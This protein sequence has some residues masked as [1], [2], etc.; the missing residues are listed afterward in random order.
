VAFSPTDETLAVGYDNEEGGDAETRKAWPASRDAPLVL[1]GHQG[2]VMA[3]S[4]SPDGRLLA[5][6]GY[7]QRVGLWRAADGKHLDWLLGHTAPVRAIS[8]SPDGRYLASAGS[9]RS[10]KVWDLRSRTEAASWLAHDQ[11][12]RALAFAPDG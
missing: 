11:T 9:D 1:A 7:D 3:L 4:Y 8:F 10:I 12:V 2:T 6:A 5:T